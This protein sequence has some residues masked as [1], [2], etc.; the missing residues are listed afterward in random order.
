MQLGAERFSALFMPH[1][2]HIFNLPYTAAHFKR[3]VQRD[4]HEH[5]LGVIRDALAAR[6]RVAVEGY[7]LFDCRDGLTRV[8][9]ED[10]VSV[11]QLLVQNRQLYLTE[12]AR[13]PVTIEQVET[14]M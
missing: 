3:D 6:Q 9:R 10:G 5:L 11:I 4:W 13:G 12:P 2:H 14:E 8:L 1:Y 7:L